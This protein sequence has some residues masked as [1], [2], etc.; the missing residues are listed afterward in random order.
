MTRSGRSNRAATRWTIR[1]IPLF[2]VAAFILG[3]YAVVYRLCVYYLYRTRGQTGLAVTFLV[4]YSVLFVLAVS[5]YLRTFLTIQLDAGFVP[6][7][8]DGHA[9]G[10]DQGPRRTRGRDAE[11]NPWVPPDQDPDSP[12]LEAFYS[13]DVFVCDADGRPK[14]CSNCRQ[15]KP[16][17]AH[18]SSELE[19]CV[20][21]MDHLCPWV[22]GMVSETSFNFFFQFT[23][24]TT[25]LCSVS[26]AAGAYC[27]QQQTSRGSSVDG[28]VT[29]AIALTS[30]FGFF[31]FAMTL[32]AARFIFTNITNIDILSKTRFFFLAVRIPSNSPPSDAFPTISY[33]LQ[34]PPV[35]QMTDAS[36][37]RSNYMAHD[38]DRDV[39][40]SRKFAILRTEPGENPWDLGFW[41]NWKSVMGNHPI[42]WL[43]PIRRSPCCNHESMDSDYQLGPLL[44]T[45]KK[46]Y[47]VPE[48]N[49]DVGGVVEMHNTGVPA[50]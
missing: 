25:C 18:H 14:W 8:R 26:V 1:I 50:A 3:T 17:R 43:L 20:R 37:P 13:K 22:G 36:S 27:L 38:T 39:R 12:G 47:G 11:A 32:T 16:D 40:A 6:L 45:L 4:L 21:K 42:D 15:W 30:I 19:R 9:D 23:L 28:W 41:R 48:L 2:I 7:I 10:K 44:A 34:R 49:G 24:Y 31:T 5:T 35:Q 33:P 46:R 29:A